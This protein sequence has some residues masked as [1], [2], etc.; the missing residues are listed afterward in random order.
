MSD[1]REESKKVDVQSV[2]D[3]VNNVSGSKFFTFF[4]PYLDFL[5]KGKT[6]YLVYIIMALVNILLPIFVIVKA[7]Q[8]GLF[9]YGGAKGISAFIFVWLFIVLAS[10]VGFQ[11]WW[12]RKSKIAAL[13]KLDFVAIPIVSQIF[14]TFGEW[15]GSFVGIVGF[16]AG[17]FATLILGRGAYSLFSAIGLDVLSEFGFLAIIIGPILGFIIIIFT[18]FL[19][20]I[21]KVFAAT[22]NNTKEIAINLKK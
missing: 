18:R 17:L 20:E 15:L 12:D 21:L 19:A 11:L 14:Q 6:F 5:D 9:E 2:I 10:W 1:D 13:D 16:G 7:A 4:K 22:A 3:S 8:E